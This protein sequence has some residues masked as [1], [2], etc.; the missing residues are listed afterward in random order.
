MAPDGVG[1]RPRLVLASASPRRRQ[2]LDS[3]GVTTESCPVDID[4]RPEPGEL[5]ADLV[6][7]LARSKAEAAMNVCGCGRRMVVIAADTV[8]SLDGE[9]F[10]KPG[11]D[12]EAR[13]MLSRLSGRSHQVLTGVAVATADRI[14]SAVETTLVHF[15]ELDAADIDCYVASGEPHDK[16]GAYGIQ[17]R[18]GL[19]VDRIEGSFHS[20]VGLPLHVVDQL[21]FSLGWSLTTWVTAT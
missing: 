14:E 12:A 13:T 15:R 2:L 8:I 3:I 16:A 19:F 11:T 7:R 9:I 4:E 20:V 21:C 18:G 6:L 17:G 10:G 5:P 1:F